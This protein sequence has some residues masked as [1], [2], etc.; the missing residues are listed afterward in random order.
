MSSSTL[1]E[2]SGALKRYVAAV[3]N[4]QEVPKPPVPEEV[5]VAEPP[6]SDPEK[7]LVTV[8]YTVKGA[9]AES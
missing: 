1:P 6:L 3:A 7:F 8:D 9:A 2:G 5:P 4:D